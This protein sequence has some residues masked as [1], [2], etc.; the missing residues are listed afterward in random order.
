MGIKTIKSRKVFHNVVDLI[1]RGRYAMIEN[2]L[3]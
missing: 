1:G 2:I 3:P